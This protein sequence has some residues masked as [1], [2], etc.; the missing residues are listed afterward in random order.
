MDRGNF[1]R[2]GFMQR[3]LAAMAATGLPAWYG[4]GILAAEEK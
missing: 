2:R 1:S 3:A 4:Q